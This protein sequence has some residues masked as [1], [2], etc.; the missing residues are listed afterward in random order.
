MQFEKPN[1]ILLKAGAWKQESDLETL[2]VQTRSAKTIIIHPDFKSE[3]HDYDL[4]II[5]TESDFKYGGV[6]DHISPIC[7]DYEN[8]SRNEHCGVLGWGE[9][10]L[11]SMFLN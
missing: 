5:V 3:T 8:L 6:N 11:K 2:K 10:V 4:A 1:D 7:I 9:E